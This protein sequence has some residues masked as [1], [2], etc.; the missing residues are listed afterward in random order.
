MCT[1][2]SSREFSD[3][4][5]AFQR[6]SRLY[7]QNRYLQKKLSSAVVDT[8]SLHINLAT[9]TK[10]IHNLQYERDQQSIAM[11][12]LQSDLHS[13][14]KKLHVR[15]ERWEEWR[16]I[17]QETRNI[18]SSNKE[19]VASMKLNHSEEMAIETAR[20][21]IFINCIT[22]R[23][24]FY[25]ARV[26]VEDLEGI[27]KRLKVGTTFDMVLIAIDKKFSIPANYPKGQG[28][29]FKHC[30]KLIILGHCW[31]QFKGLWGLDKTWL[32][33]VLLLFIGIDG[34][35]H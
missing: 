31:F 1:E 28:P 11:G 35:S 5:S 7:D 32:R 10:T 27:D 34:K 33:R 30:S 25:L 21:N 9:S 12:W 13:T 4:G 24:S 26:L 29:E 2:P 16:N 18:K 15:T 14:E 23:I 6:S 17:T 8:E 20:R 22:K 19:R 3:T